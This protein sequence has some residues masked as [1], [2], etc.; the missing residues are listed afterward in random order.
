MPTI[1][2]GFVELLC[3]PSEKE[4]ARFSEAQLKVG[5]VSGK[6]L[7][8]AVGVD[9]A[10]VNAMLLTNLTRRQYLLTVPRCHELPKS[11]FEKGP[12]ESLHCHTYSDFYH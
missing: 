10:V 1:V 3:K 6:A 11:A 7:R 4:L 8:C 2:L 5:A 9:V 12:R